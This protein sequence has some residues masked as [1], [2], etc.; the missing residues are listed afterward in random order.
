MHKC[1]TSRKFAGGDTDIIVTLSIF[2]VGKPV[3]PTG[4]QA[5]AYGRTEKEQERRLQMKNLQ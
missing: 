3:T 4:I 1:I 5:N 2:W